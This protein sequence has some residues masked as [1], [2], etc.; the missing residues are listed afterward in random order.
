M[1]DL[2]GRWDIGVANA[3]AEGGLLPMY[4]MPTRVRPLYLGLRAT[5]I[6]DYDWDTTDRDSDL[7]IYE[8]APGASLV[9]DKRVHTAVGLTSSL[10]KPQKRGGWV[11]PGQDQRSALENSWWMALCDGCGGWTRADQ[12]EASQCLAC[13]RLID[14]FELARRPFHAISRLSF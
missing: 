11:L 13:V 12:P 6:D 14:S 5:G 10:P 4:G 7:A 8:F 3:L 9:R 2:E 1:I